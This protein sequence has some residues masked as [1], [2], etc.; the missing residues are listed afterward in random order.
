MSHRNKRQ[1][2]DSSLIDEELMSQTHDLNQ[3]TNSQFVSQQADSSLIPKYNADLSSLHIPNYPQAQQGPQS[4]K[5][6]LKQE[7]DA[8]TQRIVNET[9]VAQAAQAA[10]A[11]HQQHA[12]QYFTQSHGQPQFDYQQNQQSQSQQYHL[13][14]PP[15]VTQSQSYH[16]PQVTGQQISHSGDYQQVSNRHMNTSVNVSDG[17]DPSDYL[18]TPMME[19]QVFDNVNVLKEFVKE[20]GKKN[21]FGIAIA[22][23][24][25]KAIYFTCELGGSYREKRSKKNQAGQRFNEANDLQSQYESKKIG[26]KKIRCPF[27][28]VANF[29]KKKNYWTLKIT[30]NKHNHAKLNPL[31]DFP[32]LRKRSNRV[33][34]TI[35]DLYSTGDKPSVIHQKLTAIFSDI[36]IKR[37]DIYN[38]IRILKKKGMVPTNSEIKSRKVADEDLAVEQQFHQSQ[39]PIL[40]AHGHS[41]Q[42]HESLGWPQGYPTIDAD[43]KKEVEQQAAAAVAAVQALKDQPQHYPSYP[44]HYGSQQ[45]SSSVQHYPTQQQGSQTQASYQYPTA[46]YYGNP[47]QKEEHFNIDERLLGG[48]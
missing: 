14:P 15:Q 43:N 35:K 21:E 24:N 22:H 26:T 32:M 37:E 42:S 30:E 12:Q 23:S 25:N 34:S 2:V 11:Q 5:I 9:M 48:N 7:S 3:L 13:P 17:S 31:E 40:Q 45:A 16:I 38:E 4:R 27:A 33:N 39:A 29:S 19:E 8:E 10:V 28:M 46:Q 20:F 1:K 36:V 41:G 44:Q 6:T 47:P 18:V